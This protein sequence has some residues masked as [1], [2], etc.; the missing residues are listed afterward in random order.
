MVKREAEVVAAPDVRAASGTRHPTPVHTGLATG[1]A[2]WRGT[3]ITELRDTREQARALFA[4]KLS[5]QFPGLDPT[6]RDQLQDRVIATLRDVARREALLVHRKLS[7]IVGEISAGPNDAVANAV[8]DTADGMTD[9]IMRLG[10]LLSAEAPAR[11]LPRP[12][13]PLILD[14]LRDARLPPRHWPDYAE[15]GWPDY[16][17]W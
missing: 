4:H 16:G 7:D 14:P 5:S 13:K 15:N 12:P 1:I 8:A 17:D 11:A 2:V 9:L 6:S 3:G 10:P